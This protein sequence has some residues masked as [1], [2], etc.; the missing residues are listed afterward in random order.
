MPTQEQ[1]SI[2]KVQGTILPDD[3]WHYVGEA[4]EPAFENS[5]VNDTDQE[6]R[7]IKDAAGVVHI[8]GR[9]TTGT[10]GLDIFTLPAGYRPDKVLEFAT[11]S[12]NAFGKLVV[13]TDGTVDPVSGNNASYSIN[14][15]FYVE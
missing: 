1:G 4:G 8:Q 14:C 6:A 13:R 15:S 3:K 9:V 7:F 5:W 12:N 10:I 11:S 2:E